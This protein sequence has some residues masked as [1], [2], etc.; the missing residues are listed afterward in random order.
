M[1][2]LPITA[3]GQSERD[4]VLGMHPEVYARHRTFLETCAA[5]TDPD[6]L[7]L[8]KARI[9]Q[10]LHCRE[11]LALHSPDLLAELTSWERSSSFTE[12]Q[13][14]TLEF[15][16]QVVI[17]PSVVSRELVGGLERELGTSGV[18]NFTT[19]IAAY[20]ASLRLST[21]LDLEPAP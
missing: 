10:M 16:E 14:N 7:T 5:A 6:L 15:V 1:T 17:D 13:R 18:I 11:E 2:W 12:L 19:V 8:C 20:E 4:A 9:A 21:L 3:D